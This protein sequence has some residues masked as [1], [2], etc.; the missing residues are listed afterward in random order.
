M[1]NPDATPDADSASEGTALSRRSV[2]KVCAAAGGLYLAAPMI[3]RGRFQ[4]FAQSGA[5]Y[6]AHAIDLVESSLV[7]DMLSALRGN[8]SSAHVEPDANSARSPSL[9]TA[10]DAGPSLGS[11]TRNEI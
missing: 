1:K 4:A 11:F 9:Y 6:S 2:L 7:I 8:A 10:A 5:T 3:N